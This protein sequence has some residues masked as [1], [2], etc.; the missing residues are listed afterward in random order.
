M[1][2]ASQT[3][4]NSHIFHGSEEFLRAEA[5]NELRAKLGDPSLASMNTT[6]LDG[7]KTTLPELSNTTGALPFMGEWRLVI[8]SGLLGKLEGKS[9]RPSKADAQFAE[10]LCGYLPALPPSTRLV[11]E[12]DHTLA[13]VHPVLQ[14]A[15]GHPQAVEVRHFG[16]LNEIDLRKW[17][18]QRSKAKGGTLSPEALDMLATTGDADLRLLDQEIEKLITYAGERPVSGGDV[19]KLVHAARSVDVFAMVDALGQRNG[20]RAIEQF[21]ALVADGEPPA[22]LLFM[23]SRQ[24]RMILQAKDLSERRAPISDVMKTLGAPRF[25]AEKAL[26]QSRQFSTPQLDAVYRRLLETDQSI[27]TGQSD[28]LLA[29]DTLIAEIA[30]RAGRSGH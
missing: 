30:S 16:R 19:Q 20:R 10:R 7:R 1:R 4:A 5:I 11:F 25:V 8:V 2:P 29:V 23:I 21:H 28:P 26:N 6:L 9:G 3:M 24:F 15:R 22:R 13:E 17:L 12:E 14:F 18:T 27:K